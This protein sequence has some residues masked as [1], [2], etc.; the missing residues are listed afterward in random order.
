MRK[1]SHSHEIRKDLWPAGPRRMIDIEGRS[2]TATQVKEGG[3]TGRGEMGNVGLFKC[4]SD[5]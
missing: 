3:R 1:T 4:M 5:M 2:E